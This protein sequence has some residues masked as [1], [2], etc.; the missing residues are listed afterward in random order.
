MK[1]VI[2]IFL[3]QIGLYPFVH[4]QTFKIEPD[5]LIRVTGN[6]N[7]DQLIGVGKFTNN[8][9]EKRTYQWKRINK[10]LP[11]GWASTTCVPGFCYT[12]E[13]ESGT[14]ELLPGKNGILDQ[15]FYINGI[16]GGAQTTLQLYDVA[17]PKEVVNVRY[18]AFV[19]DATTGFE[20][21]SVS[22][23]DIIV[24]QNVIEINNQKFNNKNMRLEIFD[25]QGLRKL[26]VGFIST[27]ANDYSKIDIST[28][29]P[30]FYV[31][32]LT[33]DANLYISK[34]IIIN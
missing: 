3:L 1:K 24:K 4:C 8:T 28:L 33:G 23:N 11:Q 2:L 14:F 5:T 30:G 29:S 13:I 34:K 12:A 9:D 25:G 7:D 26:A 27:P 31:L 10:S 21:G 15:N 16:A 32:Q 20:S 22:S 6:T 18:I 19:K 17:N